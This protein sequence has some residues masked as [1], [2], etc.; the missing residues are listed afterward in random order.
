MIRQNI[1]DVASWLGANSAGRL[2]ARVRWSMTS[3]DA[4]DVEQTYT[5]G[6]DYRPCPLQK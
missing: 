3:D 6:D 2:T 5:F 1:Q 4:V